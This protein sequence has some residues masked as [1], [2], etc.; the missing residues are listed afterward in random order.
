MYCMDSNENNLTGN[1]TQNDT[2]LSFENRLNY[3]KDL[4]TGYRT[5]LQTLDQRL[6]YVLTG[7]GVILGVE[8]LFLLSS[9]QC[10]VVLRIPLITSLSLLALSAI[11]AVVG[12]MSGHFLILLGR[13]IKVL[14]SNPLKIKQDSSAVILDTVN[15][16]FESLK[17]MTEEGLFKRMFQEKNL[18]KRVID[19]KL[20]LLAWTS[21]LLIVNFCVMLVIMFIKYY[22]FFC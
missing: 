21:W 18:Y 13:P 8:L 1:N 6:S 19:I 22:L 15:N 10:E 7:N 14:Q 20:R 9:K 11:I 3:L 17:L 2:P 16:S 5:Q 4:L 12:N